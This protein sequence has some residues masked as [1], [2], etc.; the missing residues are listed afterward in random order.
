M[1]SGAW[2]G[3]TDV[4]LRVEHPGRTS[5]FGG[6]SYEVVD[7]KLASETKAESVLQLCLY[8]ELLAELQGPAESF[9]TWFVRT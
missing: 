5:R 7:C 4:L 6:W 2:G 8:S 9:S 1:T 3:R